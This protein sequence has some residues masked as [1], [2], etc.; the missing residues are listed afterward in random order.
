[1][2]YPNSMSIHL[3]PDLEEALAE[4]VARGFSPSA[5]EFVAKAVRG[6]LRVL[7]ELRASLDAA[8]AQADEK[9]W[10][11]GEAVFRELIGD[12]ERKGA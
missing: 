11:D 4:E 3:P 12:L 5:D 1:M 8:E 6:R 9:G 7:Q 10:L 2:G